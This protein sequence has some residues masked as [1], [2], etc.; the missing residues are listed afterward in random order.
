MLITRP[1]RAFAHRL[2]HRLRHQKR[3]RQIRRQHIVPILLLHPHRQDVPRDHP[4][5]F[6]GDLHFPQLRD[7]RLRTLLNR[8]L[9]AQVQ[10][11]HI[12]PPAS[13]RSLNRSFRC[14]QSGAR[15]GGPAEI[16]ATSSISPSAS[17]TTPLRQLISAATA[18]SFSTPRAHSA[19]V[20]P[21]SA[22][23]IAHARPIPCDAP[24]TSATLPCNPLTLISISNSND[25]WI[26][27]EHL[28]P[29]R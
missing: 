11:K 9:T 28:A 2:H 26:N 10:R 20:A 19:T 12:R 27:Y 17:A 22:S 16:A 24:V 7:H 18:S 1:H 4:P 6:T 3:A 13:R 25:P 15:T 29:D 14:G 5:L 21:A 8:I 23:A